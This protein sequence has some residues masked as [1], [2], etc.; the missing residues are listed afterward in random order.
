ML[1]RNNADVTQCEKP[2]LHFQNK[3]VYR[4][5]ER[6]VDILCFHVTSCIFQNVKSQSPWVFSFLWLLNILNTFRFEG[7]RFDSNLRFYSGAFWNSVFFTPQDIKMAHREPEHFVSED[8]CTV[9]YL[10]P[11]VLFE[12]FRRD[13]NEAISCNVVNYLISSVNISHLPL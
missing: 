2:V 9:I 5:E 3:A 1:P 8:K 4:A 12:S 13:L 10:C 7:F 11:C 6:P